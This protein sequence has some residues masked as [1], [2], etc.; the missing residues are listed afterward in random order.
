[1]QCRD[2]PKAFVLLSVML[3]VLV[4]GMVLRVAI[5]RMPMASGLS[6]QTLHQQTAQ[7]AAQS[8]LAFALTMLGQDSAWPQGSD[9]FTTLVEDEGHLTVVQERGNILGTLTEPDGSVSEF[10]LRF[11][12]QNGEPK[13]DPDGFDN[14]SSAMEF[15]TPYVSV[16]NLTSTEP[17]VV[18][19]ASRTSGA[20]EHPEQGHTI[21][22][23]SVSL[24]VEG[25]AL[26]GQNQVLAKHVSE[27]VYLLAPKEAVEDGVIMAGGGLDI[28]L[29]SGGKL[30]FGAAKI[31]KKAPA[32][33][34]LRSKKGILATAAG[35]VPT[36]KTQDGRQVE[37]SLDPNEAN[38]VSELVDALKGKGKEVKEQP[39]ADFYSLPS[40]AIKKAKAGSANTATLAAGTYVTTRNPNTDTNRLIYYQMEGEEYLQLEPEERALVPGGVDVTDSFGALMK[41]GDTSKIKVEDKKFSIASQEIS[42]ILWT[43]KDID[44]KIEPVNRNDG[45]PALTGFALVPETKVQFTHLDDPISLSPQEYKKSATPDRILLDMKNT[46]ISCEGDMIIY[47]GVRGK[48][49]TLTSDA[50]V[51][52]LAG[53]KLI[54]ER[55]E[56][57]TET[58]AD[59]DDTDAESSDAD[60]RNATLQ[61]NIYAEKDLS[62]SSY[63]AN[64]KDGK[65]GYRD[66][67]FKGLLYSWGDVNIHAAGDSKRQGTLKLKGSLVAYGNDPTTNAP[68]A[69]SDSVNDGRVSIEAK[70]AILNWDPSFL[71]LASLKGGSTQV[72][73]VKYAVSFPKP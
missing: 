35:R 57:D 8:G 37:F 56:K 43:V 41:Q 19:R 45:A 67:S 63:S 36:I 3:I 55:G 27:A 66:L 39:N 69:G 2:K 53:R 32:V 44:L 23:V 59:P 26:G 10:R 40:E 21:P 60:G 50:N 72:G 4:L 34:R 6:R 65:G 11:N 70:T 49:A 51:K 30:Q 5:L 61:L 28:T 71:R 68:G 33:S 58:P 25:R 38:N 13:D 64:V 22:E 15:E 29:D 12:Y 14:P 7:R 52:L 31:D 48:S 18:P 16:N 62:I 73:F 1:M 46:T 9:S 24:A 42:G 17:A 47:G 54:L 20:V